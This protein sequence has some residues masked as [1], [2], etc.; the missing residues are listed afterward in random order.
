MNICLLKEKSTMLTSSLNLSNLKGSHSETTATV[1][2]GIVFIDST[3]DDY[4]MLMAG[5]KPGLEV[6][7]LD[8]SQNGITQITEALKGRSG[9]SSLHIVAHG[10]VG[11][12]WVGMGFVNSHTLEQY[13]Q[14]LHSW[15]AALAPDG[16]ILLYGCNIAARDTGRQFVGLFSQLTGA[17]VAASNNLTG[18]AALGGDWELEVKIGNIEAPIAFGAE[19]VEAYNAVLTT[20]LV[21]VGIDDTQANNYSYS[22]SISA[23]GRYVAFLS[24]A[25]NLVSGDTNNEGD[26]F[27]YDTAANTTRRVSVGTGGIQ[28]NKNSG[29]SSI[30]AD[31]RYVAFDSFASNLVSGDTNNTSDIFVYDTVANTTRR[32]SVDSN[33]T[34]GNHRSYSGSISADGRYVAFG[35]YAS[36]LVS[37]DTNNERDIFVYDTVTNTTRRVSIDSNGIQG[38]SSSYNPSISAD[39]RYVAFDSFA[40]NL[41]SGDTNDTWDIFVYDTVANSTRRVSFDDNGIQGNSSSGYASISADGRYV[42]FESYASNLVSGDTNNELDIFVYDTVTNTTRRV[43]IDSNG[44]QGNSRSSNAS[45]SAD[46]RYVV[47]NSNAS[48]LVSG[49]TNNATDIFVYDTV[50]NTTR[51]VSVDSGARGNDGFISADGSY[52]AFYSYANNLASGETNG[53]SD[54][55]IYDRGYGTQNP[56]TGTP[57]D[58]TYTYTGTANFTG[59]G[60]AG[61]DT[62]VGG[63]GNDTL[64]G[65]TGNDS[66]VGGLGDDTYYVDSYGGDRIVENLNE[67]ID[68]VISSQQYQLGDNL[69]NLSLTGTATRGFGNSLDNRIIGNSQANYLVGQAGNDILWG[70]AGNDNLNGN[71]GNDRLSGGDG[72]DTLIGEC[73]SDFL[74]GGNG[75]N[76]FVGYGNTSGER[77]TLVGG[78]GSDI[79]GVGVN[80]ARFGAVSGSGGLVGYTNDGKAGFALIRGWDATDFIELKGDF[81]QYSFGQAFNYGDVNK[82]D[83]TISYYGAN[84]PDLI[85]V[86]QDATDLSPDSFIF[87]T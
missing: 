86:V 27:V 20:R 72:N 67:G 52:V 49:D 45:I 87:F 34:Q 6:V 74:L 54:I 11:E 58:D 70:G 38:N 76:L 21:S 48:N 47:F 2:S 30:S 80:Y 3:V 78:A 41:V 56:W 25:S 24:Y 69:E 66:L 22:P 7:L 64:I 5:V 40:S 75:N 59:S 42:A 55:F 84:T 26:I 10:D 62:I 36:N 39:G 16:D 32:V 46:G 12:L 79:F 35:S 82:A 15:A 28:G 81:S 63:I 44:I 61:N 37:G 50:A 4:E 8:D 14:D 71:D 9:L 31:G 33:G 17:D 60:L 77:D 51:L 1:T 43:S 19:T 23:N 13:K 53:Y 18:S 68:T 57:F 85:A 29:Y 83:L 65:G 73:G